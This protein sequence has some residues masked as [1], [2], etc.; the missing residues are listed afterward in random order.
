TLIH[1]TGHWLGLKHTFGEIVHIKGEDCKK[2]DGLL[3]TSYKRLDGR[4]IQLHSGALR[5]TGHR[6]TRDLQLD[7][8]KPAL[9]H[10]AHY[11]TCPGSLCVASGFKT[12]QKAS[13][14]AHV[15]Y[16]RRSIKNIECNSYKP[17]GSVSKRS[18]MQ[19]LVDG[20][21]PDVDAAAQELQEFQNQDVDESSRP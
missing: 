1:E 16:S 5:S 15:L 3:D 17:D 19:D 13:M 18:T 2:G 12:N 8:W 20:K 9:P 7:E 4:G 21:C 6:P 10:P 11:S 14:F